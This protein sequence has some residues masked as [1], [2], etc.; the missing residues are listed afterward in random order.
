MNNS[1][2]KLKHI[3]QNLSEHV[4]YAKFTLNKS[5]VSSFHKGNK[6]QQYLAKQLLNIFKLPLKIYKTENS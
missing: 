1:K 6:F 3:T 4:T 2:G 5:T